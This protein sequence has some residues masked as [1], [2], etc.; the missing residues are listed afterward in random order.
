MTAQT[1]AQVAQDEIVLDDTTAEFIAEFI[2]LR[3]EI[4]EMEKEKEAMRLLI[5]EAMKDARVGVHNGEA[6][7]KI[8]EAT[9]DRVKSMKDFREAFPEAY[10]AVT[11]ATTAKRIL[12]L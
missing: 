8:V 3:D 10:K 6:I 7:V 4:T 1:V 2:R 5:L 12:P 11:H 9:Q